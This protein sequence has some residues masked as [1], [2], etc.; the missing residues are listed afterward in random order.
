MKQLRRVTHPGQPIEPRILSCISPHGQ[1]MFVRLREGEDLFN[2]TAAALSSIGVETSGIRIAGG[3]LKSFSYCTGVED[4]SGYRVATFSEPKF[5][6]PPITLIAGNI[7]LGLDEDGQ[8]KTHCHAVFADA[9]GKVHAG[10]LL[11]GECAVG[12]QGASLF[13]SSAGKAGLQVQFDPET[14]FPIFHPTDS[15][16]DA[17]MSETDSSSTVENGRF[18]RVITARIRPNTDFVTGIEEL[19][20]AHDI[21]HG[22]IRGCVGSLMDATLAS[23]TT[24]EPRITEVAGPGLEIAVSC[25]VVRLGDND[26]PRAKLSGLVANGAGEAYAGEFVRGRNLVFVTM[27]VVLQEWLPDS[28]S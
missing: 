1:D 11:P 5:P 21:S 6:P 24:D 7:I 14:N 9:A 3:G 17:K 8:L 25:G 13:V 16:G 2:G 15:Q 10:H 19:C 26:F 20:A 27:E 22:E 12:E 23:G 28:A 18:G 4:P